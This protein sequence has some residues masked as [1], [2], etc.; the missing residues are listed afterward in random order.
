[1]S[2]SNR[3]LP[4]FTL[5]LTRPS[6]EGSSTPVEVLVMRD[7]QQ[8][9]RRE[10]HLNFQ[11][12]DDDPLMKTVDTRFAG[13]LAYDA[14]YANATTSSLS[15]SSTSTHDVELDTEFEAETEG[16][17]EPGAE[18]PPLHRQP[19]SLS[20]FA[21][22]PRP[23]SPPLYEPEAIPLRVLREQR[24]PGHRAMPSHSSSHRPPPRSGSRFSSVKILLSIL[25]LFRS[26]WRKLKQAGGTFW[27]V[28]TRGPDL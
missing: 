5:V 19:A 1:M 23:C 11:P 13:S 8:A 18:C 17:F 4:S 27:K 21:Q 28:S 3:P 26:L 14:D 20:S 22:H 25:K 9:S 2:L 16:E 12:R 24:T 6:V 15:S 7:W 10:V